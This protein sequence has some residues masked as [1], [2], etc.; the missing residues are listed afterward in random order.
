[1][2]LFAGRRVHSQNITGV[3]VRK[4]FCLN[5]AQ[6]QG[7]WKIGINFIPHHPIIHSSTK[8]RPSTTVHC[9]WTLA[10]VAFSTHTISPSLDI[11]LFSKFSPYLL[12]IYC[13]FRATQAYYIFVM[14]IIL[15]LIV[16]LQWYFNFK[17]GAA[18]WEN[19]CKL[20]SS[21]FW[22]HTHINKH[23]PSLRPQSQGVKY[24]LDTNIISRP[25]LDKFAKYP[26]TPVYVKMLPFLRHLLRRLA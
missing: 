23:I 4:E 18:P 7:C 1:M 12:V 26:R 19:S 15:Q 8:E 14:E 2:W 25:F 6:G 10:E 21:Y 20:L 24:C 17:D 16:F 3:S 5:R 9:K 11:I 13:L 22:H